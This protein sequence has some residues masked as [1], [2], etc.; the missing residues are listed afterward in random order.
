[1]APKDGES[2]SQTPQG[3]FK[4]LLSARDYKAAMQLSEN[5]RSLA[6]KGLHYFQTFED[7]LRLSLL[8]LLL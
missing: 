4:E 7:S 6:L 3:V 5:L 1:M 2:I 8:F